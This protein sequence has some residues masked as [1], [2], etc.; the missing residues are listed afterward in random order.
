MSHKKQ[1]L[2]MKCLIFFTM[3]FGSVLLYAQEFTGTWKGDLD[4][5]GSKLPLV[6]HIEKTDSGYISTMDSPAQ[7]AMGLKVATTEVSGENLNFKMPDLGLSYAGKLKENTIQGTFTQYGTELPLTLSRSTKSESVLVRPQEPHPPYDYLVEEVKIKNEK[8]GNL[9]AGSL[10]LPKNFKPSQPMVV[11]ITG[12]G[13]QNRDEE[14]FGHKPFL[15]LA[16][17]LA[18]KGIASLR[19]DDRG[20]GSSEKGK[21]D[22]TTADFATDIDAAVRYLSAKGYTNIGLIGHSEGGMIAPMVA[23]DNKNV[24]FLVLLAAPG[25]PIDELM[26][27]QNH[28][29]LK[30]NGA[31]E[32]FLKN[33]DQENKKIYDFIIHYKGSQLSQ[34][35]QP[36]VKQLLQSQQVP[37]AQLENATEK[38]VETLSNPWFLYFIKFNPEKYLSKIKIPVLALNGS[39]DFQVSAKENLVAIKSSLTKA[40]NK[41]FETVEIPHLNHLFQTATTGNISEYAQIE[42]TFS[43][44]A[45]ALITNW[46]LQL[47]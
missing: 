16:D 20:M 19:M 4:V 37:E 6:L 31:S 8:E 23:D 44:K 41:N 11:M 34:D 43:P 28:D 39:L 9:L 36:L 15:V 13:P 14:L 10:V 35:L 30:L 3:L 21:D 29:L 38:T 2:Q 18:K 32:T 7:G 1:L 33:L 26:I 47:K 42:E 46:I 22:P 27:Q 12:S 5:M 24:K 17:A 40:G 25:V 45:L